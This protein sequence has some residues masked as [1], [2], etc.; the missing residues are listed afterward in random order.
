MSIKQVSPGEANELLQQGWTYID[1][2]S[3]PEFE[4]G[5]PEG[6]YNVPLMHAEPGLGMEPNPDF[7]AVMERNFSRDAQLIVGCK[8][9]ARSMRAAEALL[10]RGFGRVLNMQG[11]FGGAARTPGWQACGL[12]VSAAAA[13][14][15]SYRELKER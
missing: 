2:R 11:G 9:G 1:V 5:H 6:A 3:V 8:S 10:E 4:E 7:I 14:G 15:R 12:P 13:P